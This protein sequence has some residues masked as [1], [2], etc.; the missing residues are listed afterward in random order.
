[1]DKTKVKVGRNSNKGFKP[2]PRHQRLNPY[3]DPP[4]IGE[5]EMQKGLI[6]LM[7]TGFIPKDVDVT[8]AFERGCPTLNAKKMQI[9][10]QKEYVR[11][12]KRKTDEPK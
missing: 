11:S 2:L 5:N 1:M 7:N 12:F 10:D 6:T 3:L 9:L 8:P 4:E